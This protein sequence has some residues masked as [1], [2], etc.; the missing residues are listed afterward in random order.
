LNEAS[1]QVGGHEQNFAFFIVLVVTSED[2]P[3]LGIEVSPKIV[4]GLLIRGTVGV[5][6]LP[7]I[8][9][10]RRWV[11]LVKNLEWVIFLLLLRNIIFWLLLIIFLL[12][13]FLFLLWLFFLLFL[14]LWLFLLWGLFLLILLWFVGLCSWGSSG[15]IWN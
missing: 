1:N 3:T 9:D 6:L 10:E 7:G 5:G 13:W 14:F 12:L 8:H 11:G 4:H 2:R 15:A